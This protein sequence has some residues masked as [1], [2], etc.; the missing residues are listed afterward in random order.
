[1]KRQLIK[2]AQYGLVVVIVGFLIIQV[3]PYGRNHTNPP[4]EQEPAWDS[5]QT[6]SLA[7][8][9]CF[10]CHSNETTLPWYRNVAPV[11]WL[12]LHDV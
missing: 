11:S 4:V 12:V 6:R 3:V 10:V 9:A 1:M 2:V 8:R 7:E 5:P